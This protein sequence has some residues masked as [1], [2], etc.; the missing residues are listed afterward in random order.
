MEKSSSDLDVY[1]VHLKNMTEVTMFILLGFTDD[2][3]LQ[4]VLF[5]VFLAIYLFTL[6]GNLGLVVLVI[7][8]TQL[9]N[10]MYYFLSV[11]SFLDACYSTVVT[12]KM[13]VNFLVKDKSISFHGCVAQMLLFI[14]FGSTESFLLAAMAYDRYVAIYHPLLYSVRMSPRVYVP[15]ITAS[16]AGGILHAVLHTG[17]TFSLSFCGSN[18]IRHVFCDIPPLLAISCSDTH[19]NQLLLFYFVGAIE[20]VTILIVLISYGFILLAILR[21]HSAEGRRK[22]FSTCGSHLTGVSIYHGTIL[23]M[24]V[25]PSSSYTL[26]HDMVVSIF[27][28]IVIPMLNPIIYSLRN[29]DVKEAMQRLIVSVLSFL[30]A[31]YSTVVTLKM[32]VNFLT[33][34]KTISFLGYATQ[35]LLFVAL[36]TTECFLLATMA[37]DCYV[38][39]Y[40]PSLDSVRMSH[41]VYVPLITA[42][43]VGD[44]VYVMVHTVATFSLS[45]C[46]SNKIRHVFCDIPPLLVISYSDTHTNQLLLFYFVGAIV[47]VT[48]LTVLISYGFILLVILRMHSAEGRRKEFFTCGSHGVLRSKQ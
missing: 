48:I 12:P 23:F 26:E 19:T 36:G 34:D 20:V 42:S 10:P 27:Y 38:T 31:Y 7:G 21:M 8:D 32:L 33:K 28:T 16:Y 35:V 46:G 22:V 17:A 4:A 24:Y 47:V 13:L 15:L 14:S 18:E 39:I 30:G 25:R 11:L 3:D 40:H 43:Y 44:F 41:K 1:K 9:H 2:G 5:L 45:F 6:I 29:K 37:Y